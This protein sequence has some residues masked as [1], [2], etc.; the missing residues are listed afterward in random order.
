[1]STSTIA[2]DVR[3]RL[4]FWAL[5]GLAL[6]VA[7]DA[8]FLA[9]IGPGQALV[10]ALRDAGHGYWSLA[11]LLLVAAAGIGGISIWLRVRHLRRRASA[12]R[13]A[14]SPS[15]RFARRFLAAWW[16]LAALVAV[17]FAVQENAE[18]LVAH[19]HAPIAGALLGPEYPLALPVIGFVTGIAAAVAALVARTQ[20]ALVVAIEA[21]LWRTTRAPR[22]GVRA[23]GILLSRTGS[24]LARRGAGRAPPALAFDRIT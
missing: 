18:H 22:L 23:P 4:A 13:A 15:G 16:R 9:Q 12:L 14:P 5:A 2:P 24:V 11:S 8:V 1:V 6:F 10:A 17:A 7:H 3:N 20:E 21:A 19:G